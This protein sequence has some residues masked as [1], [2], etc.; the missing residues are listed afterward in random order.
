ME[1]YRREVGQGDGWSNT[2]R[3]L[4]DRP[5][6]F[7]LFQGS[8]E[9]ETDHNYGESNETFEYAFHTM[10]CERKPI[11]KNYKTYSLSRANLD[12]MDKS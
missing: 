7:S 5:G 11:F 8:M 1:L 10:F 4:I 9:M 2:L 6:V 3:S 12:I